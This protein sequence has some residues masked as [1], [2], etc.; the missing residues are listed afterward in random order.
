MRVSLLTGLKIG[1][2]KRDAR[3]HYAPRAETLH[4][5]VGSYERVLHG[6]TATFS[7]ASTKNLATPGKRAHKSLIEKKAEAPEL[8]EAGHLTGD[9]DSSDANVNVTFTDA[10]LLAAHSSS[11]RAVAVSP[12][13]H[14][15]R[16]LASG[17]ADERITVYQIGAVAPPAD[18]S[19]SSSKESKKLVELKP[20]KQDALVGREL[21]TLT[22][23]AA[24][25]TG[26][27][28]CGHAKLL[29]T[30]L[31]NSICIT[32]TRDWTPLTTLRAPHP[33]SA[34][35][36]EGDTY[37]PGEGPSGVTSCGVHPSFKLGVS[38]GVGERAMRLWDLVKGKKA[39]VLTFEKGALGELGEWGSLRDGEGKQVEWDAKGERFVVTFEKGVAMFDMRCKIKGLS[40]V[41]RGEKVGC[42]RW[43]SD[44]VFAVATERGRVVFFSAISDKAE[45]EEEPTLSQLPEVA[46][47]ATPP[48]TSGTLCRIRDFCVLGSISASSRYVITG[49]SDGAV[50][51]YDVS[52]TALAKKPLSNG[53]EGT[54]GGQTVGRLMATHETGHRITCLTA[55]VM[56]LPNHAGDGIIGKEDDFGGF[57]DD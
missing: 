54:N 40:K 14:G 56:D 35:R 38:V 17:G 55:F 18:T 12:S 23:H 43:F 15:K 21:G 45:H 28:F 42:V 27:S 7:P 11:I 4:V 1:K 34:H 3:E 39:G 51:I 32:R 47:L 9:A 41:G 49:S 48:T 13:L 24:T 20:A 10:F 16:Y 31:D 53:H 44:N 37:A 57:S 30:S 5:T 50:R 8:D 33:I 46:Q 6:F 22:P 25:I 19:S 26:L 29:S 52:L 36:P 2:R